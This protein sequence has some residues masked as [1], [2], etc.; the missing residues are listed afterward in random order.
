MLGTV[1]VSIPVGQD[2]PVALLFT[3]LTE[4]SVSEFFTSLGLKAGRQSMGTWHLATGLW[5]MYLTWATALNLSV[6][7]KLLP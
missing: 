4:F 1:V 2:V 6:G 5:L 3:G 7:F